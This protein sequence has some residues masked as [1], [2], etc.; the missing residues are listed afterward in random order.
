M[1]TYLERVRQQNEAQDSAG[2][3]AM[4]AACL[5]VAVVGFVVSLL[6]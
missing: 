6:T 1:P 4:L 3:R 5:V 2:D